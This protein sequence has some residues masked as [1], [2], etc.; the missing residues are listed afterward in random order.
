MVTLI[1]I[2]YFEINTTDFNREGYYVNSDRKDGKKSLAIVTKDI[3]LTAIE[4]NINFKNP[5]LYKYLYTK[6]EKI[7]KLG[8][9]RIEKLKSLSSPSAPLT[10]TS[11]NISSIAVEGSKYNS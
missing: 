1:G 9:E 11:T 6:K 3:K 5:K 4:N 2:S 10:S 8:E 7:E